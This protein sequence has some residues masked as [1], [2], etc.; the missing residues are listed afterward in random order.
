MGGALIKAWL[1]Y[2]RQRFVGRVPYPPEIQAIEDL[3]Y[4]LR[5]AK[6]HLLEV[7][8]YGARLALPQWG[9]RERVS[10]GQLVK[11]AACPP[12]KGR[13]LYQ[14]VRS[15]RPQRLLELGTHVGMGT[16]Y[17]GLAAPNAELHTVE[18]SPTL[19]AYARR[20]TRLFGLRVHFH[21]GTFSEVLPTLPGPWDLVYLDGDHRGQA[22]LTYAEALWP[23]LP[24]GG[25]LVCDDIFWSYDMWRGWKAL[26]KFPWRKRWLIGPFAIAQR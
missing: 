2:G 20:H 15:H 22:L 19:L 16:L 25:W 9:R 4:R 8:R 23:T 1:R 6:G 21:V 18:A 26:Q 7:E 24:P 10:L 13:L 14:M 3:F 5:R 11:Q 12:W 17:L